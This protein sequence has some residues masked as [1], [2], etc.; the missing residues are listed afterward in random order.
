MTTEPNDW[1]RMFG[2]DHVEPLDEAFREKYQ[3][4]EEVA[5]IV[6]L[7]AAILA[8][9]FEQTADEALDAARSLDGEE[10]ANE[11]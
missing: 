9:G 6:A 11:D 10:P 7:G 2:L 8:R 1:A 5:E 3:M 4:S